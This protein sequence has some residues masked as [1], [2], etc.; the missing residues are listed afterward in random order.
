MPKRKAIRPI[1]PNQGLIGNMTKYGLCKMLQF[2]KKSRMPQS[3]SEPIVTIG[4]STYQS[5]DDESKKKLNELYPLPKPPTA[6]EIRYAWMR[7]F[8]RD[9]KER[10]SKK[11]KT[12]EQ[13][14]FM[15]LDKKDK[16]DKV[17]QKAYQ[18]QVVANLNV[19]LLQTHGV[20]FQDY[21]KK[22][23]GLNK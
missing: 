16:E 18:K 3:E 17:R 14:F 22:A 13:L 15:F 21:V 23:W 5:L 9:K 20:T 11:G 4:Y 8:F 12:Q 7:E 19:A 10:L 2:E 1:K 6:K